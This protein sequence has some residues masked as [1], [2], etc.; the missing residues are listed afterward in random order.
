MRSVLVS[1]AGRGFYH[2]LD[3]YKRQTAAKK[4][5]RDRTAA[6]QAYLGAHVVRKL[7]LGAGG[8]VLTGW[9]NSDISPPNSNVSFLD[10]R[11]PFPFGD[12]TFDYIFCEHL[13]E[14]LCY[15]EGQSA[16]RECYRVLKCCGKVRIATPNLNNILALSTAAKGGIQEKYVRWS[17]AEFGPHLDSHL[18]G[19]VLNNFFR[20]WGHEFIYDAD[21]MELTLRTT[22]FSGFRWFAVGESEDDNLRNIEGHGRCIGEEMNRVETMVVEATRPQPARLPSAPGQPRV[23]LT[24]SHDPR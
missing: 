6:I 20:L 10:A 5:R 22:G 13:M 11:E 23:G 1:A 19:F 21:T 15:L 4:W 17:N 16:L 14:H 2:A 9:L 18:P 3:D 12:Y 8:N 24:P 7:Q